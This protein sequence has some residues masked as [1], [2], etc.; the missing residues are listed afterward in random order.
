MDIK[1]NIGGEGEEQ[2]SLVTVVG[3]SCRL[4][5]FVMALIKFTN[6]WKHQADS[7]TAEFTTEAKPCGCNDAK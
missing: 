2:Q 4:P 5:D 6:E 3:C 7:V 1:I